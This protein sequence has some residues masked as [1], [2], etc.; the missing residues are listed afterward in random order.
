MLKLFIE[1]IFQS[2]AHPLKI[3]L[4]IVIEIKR[5]LDN[6][7]LNFHI[8]ETPFATSDDTS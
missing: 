2:T 8:Y 4:R 7:V 3:Y 5:V 6:A 1:Q